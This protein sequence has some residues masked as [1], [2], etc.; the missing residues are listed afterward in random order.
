MLF[1]CPACYN[2]FTHVLPKQFGARFDFKTKFIADY[3]LE[4]IADGRLRLDHPMNRRAVVHDSCQGR[5]LGPEFMERQ[6]ELLRAAGVTPVDST[7][8]R[9]EGLCCG[10]AAGCNRFDPRDILRASGMA[11]RMARKA[12]APEMAVYCGGCLLML[13]LS[14]F[15]LP[16]SLP[17]IHSLQYVQEAA[18][19]RPVRAQ[20]SR[21]LRLAM[22]VLLNAFPVVLSRRRF[23]VGE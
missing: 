23:R 19:E 16:G 1:V 10:I 20:S 3:L 22:G 15:A 12:G 21:A 5:I 17:V 13:S 9:E 18:G 14:R 8:A 11:H 4:R 7:A 2:M 6:R